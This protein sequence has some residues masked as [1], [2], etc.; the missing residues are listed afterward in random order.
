MCFR[1]KKGEEEGMELGG[2]K[3]TDREEDEGR[4][5]RRER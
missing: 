4:S 5:K 3:E 2:E 1:M